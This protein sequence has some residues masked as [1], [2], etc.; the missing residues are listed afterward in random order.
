MTDLDAIVRSIKKRARTNAGHAVAGSPHIDEYELEGGPM[1]LAV[2]YV[3]PSLIPAVKALL[4]A[5]H[6]NPRTSQTEEVTRP[7]PEAN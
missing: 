3:P 6:G 1:V 5:R 7:D 2:L 4:A